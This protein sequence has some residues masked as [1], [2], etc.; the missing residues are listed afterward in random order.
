MGILTMLCVFVRSSLKELNAALACCLKPLSV[1]E[2]WVFVHREPLHR[3]RTSTDCSVVIY[4]S[5]PKDADLIALSVF[6]VLN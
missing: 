1:C 6:N 4:C 3:H 5:T 2:L